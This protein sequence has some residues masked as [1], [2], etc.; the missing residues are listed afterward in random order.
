MQKKKNKEMSEYL[1][2]KDIHIEGNQATWNIS[3]VGDILG[4]YTGTFRFK[5]FLTPSERLAAGRLYR[6][7]L[8]SNP[9][10]VTEHEDNLALTL[11]QLKFRII[12]GPPF[13][14][15]AIGLDE[16][17]GDI[18]DE[19]VLNSILDAASASEL[20]FLAQ[21]Q[22]KKKDL[23]EKAKKAAEKV[24]EQDDEDEDE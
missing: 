17:A 16:I 19:M 12:S 8:G 15:S 10:L 18:P 7:L 14:S 13:W 23:I 9:T 1:K 6:E 11:S 22:E 2:R 5:C 21:L 24:L 3:T 4:T 20:K